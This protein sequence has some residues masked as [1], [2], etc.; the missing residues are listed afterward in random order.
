MERLQ[1]AKIEVETKFNTEKWAKIAEAME[2]KG[3]Q[4]FST[5]TIQKKVKELEKKVV[6]NDTAAVKA[7]D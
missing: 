4:K 2:G 5:A 3:S 6:V 1:E 7:E